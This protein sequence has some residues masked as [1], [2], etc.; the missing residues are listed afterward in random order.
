[1]LET[2]TPCTCRKGGRRGKD[3]CEDPHHRLLASLRQPSNVT[4]ACRGDSSPAKPRSFPVSTARC[5]AAGSP[6][7]VFF[8]CQEESPTP[9]RE[10]DVS[11]DG[12]GWRNPRDGLLLRTR[13]GRGSDR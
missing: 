9:S 6:A 8:A 11:P 4:S 10:A 3:C 2:I 7:C 5:R 13:A 12:W 1:M